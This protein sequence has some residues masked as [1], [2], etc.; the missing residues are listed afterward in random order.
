MF[1][2]KVLRSNNYVDKTSIKRFMASPLYVIISRLR[3]F[4]PDNAFKNYL[5][6]ISFCKY[7]SNLDIYGKA[8]GLTLLI[9]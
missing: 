9:E 2:I 6:T 4:I 5:V 7:L 3:T 8:K 1:N